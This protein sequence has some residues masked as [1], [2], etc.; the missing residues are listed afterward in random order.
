MLPTLE[1][2]IVL[3][4]DAHRGRRDMLG[5]PYIL[6]PLRLTSRLAE[7]P[8]QT[9]ALLHDVISDSDQLS[10]ISAR[11]GTIQRSSRRSTGLTGARLSHSRTSSSAS[12]STSWRAALISPTSRTTSTCGIRRA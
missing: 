1:D 8:D 3:A 11:V 5:R 6:H 10:T 9:A 12:A 4:V 2:A 7:P